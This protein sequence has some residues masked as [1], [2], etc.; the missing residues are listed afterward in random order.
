VE[1]RKKIKFDIG[2]PCK[3]WKHRNNTKHEYIEA[4][5]GTTFLLILSVTYEP[6]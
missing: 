6:G 3:E 5:Y 1:L 4:K 2:D